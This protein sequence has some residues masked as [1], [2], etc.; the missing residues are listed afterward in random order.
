MKAEEFARR[1]V[2]LF[3]KRQS[4][5][6]NKV[7]VEDWVPGTF[8]SLGKACFLFYVT[9]LDYAIKSQ[10]LYEGALKL[11]AIN[12]KFFLPSTILGLTEAELTEYLATYIRPRYINE[13]V[14]RYKANSQKLNDQYGGDPQRI[15]NDNDATKVLKRIWEFR[16]FGPKT[17]NLFFRS[18]VTTFGIMYSNIDKV[19]PPVDMHDV[20]I[21]KLLGYVTNDDMSERN[22]QRV[23]E[24][25][26]KAC[27]DAGVNWLTFD[28]AL[29]LLGSVGRPETKEDI[30]RLLLL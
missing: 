16:G 8:N 6:Q 10:L 3:E 22:V 27:L 7:N 29:W 30:D 26:N 28:K 17:G 18:M 24:L 21:A 11:I 20:R 13:A 23:K 12:P 15:F 4:V 5:F 14:F 19:L 2:E 25:W 9:Q 1:V